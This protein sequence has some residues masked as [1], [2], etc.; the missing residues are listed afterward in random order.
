MKKSL[1]IISLFA[2]TVL[3]AEACQVDLSD[4]V[5]PTT[6]SIPSQT[7]RID[8]DAQT[9]TSVPIFSY[10]SS[11]QS[12]QISYINCLNGTPFGKSP[13]NLGPQDTSTKIYPTSVPG[14]GIKLRWNNG[15][16]FG[17]FPSDNKMSFQTP[18]G[19]FIYSTGSY[20]RI[21][22]YKTQPRVSLKDP[23]GDILLP[24]GD[25]AYNWVEMNSI[26]N[27]AQK[28]NIGQILV[29]STPAC[30]FNNNKVV[31]FGLVTS[32]DLTAGGIE[33]D[34]SFDIT[35]QSDYGNYSAIAAITSNTPSA[36]K[37]YIKVKDSAG[38]S[39]RLGIEIKDSQGKTMLLDGSTSELLANV[40]ANTPAT[41]HWKAH[42]KPTAG[43]LHPAN[44]DF[45]AEAEI[46]LQIK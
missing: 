30:A 10:D 14:I 27:Y 31:D 4:G 20:F 42:L 22:L 33:K 44:G 46:I 24:P 43:V 2:F 1:F 21:E 32:A 38:N 3:N 5:G 18:L 6:L 39:D 19:R 25:I 17:D 45:T 12:T 41:F 16:A 23:N 9:S 28:L 13:Y 35:C 8:A 11:L 34:L 26:S 40:V 29:I 15:S 7:I 37:Q 36:D